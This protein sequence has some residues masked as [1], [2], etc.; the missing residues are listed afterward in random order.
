[1][2]EN[3]AVLHNANWEISIR[4]VFPSPVWHQLNFPG[5]VSKGHSIYNAYVSGD[6]V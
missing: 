2:C 3:V 6:R 5:A 1:M 4:C